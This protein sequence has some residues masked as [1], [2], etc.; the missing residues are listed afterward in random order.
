MTATTIALGATGATTLATAFQTSA[1]PQALKALEINVTDD[2]A[3]AAYAPMDLSAWPLQ[4]QATVTLRIAPTV[5]TDVIS[6][7]HTSFL[8]AGLQA[9][10][11]SKLD[12]GTRIVTAVK[13]EAAGS[14]SAPIRLN[15]DDD[16]IDEDNLLADASNVLAPPPAMSDVKATDDCAGREPCADCTCGRSE[17]KAVGEKQ[18]VKSSSCGKC[19]LGDAF[20]CN[21]CPFLGKPAFKPGEEH[22]VLDLQDDL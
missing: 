18:A 2:T 10:G 8:L 12:N 4:D 13:K 22:L 19:H 16:M 15:L 21:S 7:I 5:T 3:A 6:K 20:R 17:N 14:N 9:V 1:P 11:E